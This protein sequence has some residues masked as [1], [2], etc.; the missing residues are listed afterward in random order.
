MANEDPLVPVFS[1]T[2]IDLLTIMEKQKGSP[3]TEEEV[4][5]LRDKGT[6]IM[7]R[8][9]MVPKMAEKRGYSDI[10]PKNAWEEWQARRQ[11]GVD[12][13]RKK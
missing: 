2:L 11:R 8:E 3:L 13:D 9:S 6:C 5:E 4:L 7:V 1:P 12:A 10:D